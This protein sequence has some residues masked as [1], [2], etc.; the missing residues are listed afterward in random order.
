MRRIAAACASLLFLVSLLLS[1]IDVCCFADS[2]YN[3]EYR[4]G[5]QAE[6]IGMS[7]EGLMDATVTLL[8]YLHDKRDDIVV[9]T[10]VRG[11]MR[12]VYNMRE[13]LHMTD[14]KALYQNA[15]KARTIF[16]IVSIIILAYLYFS[17]RTAFFRT[18]LRG[19]QDA[20]LLIILFVSFVAVWCIVDFNGFWMQFHYIFF[21]NDLFLLDPNTSIM[22]N[23]FPESFFFDIVVLIIIVFAACAALIT[24]LCAY[25]A[26]K[27]A[28]A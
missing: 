14:V 24:G 4:K 17:G 5:A 8:D 13:T 10:E 1:V 9:S 7:E 23:M 15:M 25:G 22:I 20:L 21:D 2:F 6:K 28:R 27:E 19:L 18:A 3:Y 11:E 26:R 12:E 16:L